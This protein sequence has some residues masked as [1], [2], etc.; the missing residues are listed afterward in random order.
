[1]LLFFLGVPLGPLGGGVEGLAAVACEAFADA[2]HDGGVD[3]DAGDDGLALG[4]G[5][6]FGEELA[7]RALDR[8]GD[9]VLVDGV[10]DAH[11]DLRH[12]LREHVL[13]EL[14]GALRDEADADAELAALGENLLEDVG[15]DDRL[16][17]GREAVRLLDE[18]PALTKGQAVISGVGVNTPV[19]C[20]VRERITRHGGE[21]FDAPA[22]WA[23]YHS[24]EAQQ[25]RAQDTAILGKPGSGKKVEKVRGIQI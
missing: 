9:G 12:A 23:K 13:V 24:R 8:L 3:A 22:E 6:E 5:G 2:A 21:T 1:M 20:R 4:E 25:R 15:G 19:M 11:D 17:R 18:L 16:A 14:A 7:A 10:D